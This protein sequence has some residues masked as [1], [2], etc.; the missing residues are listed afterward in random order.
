[1][2]G[3]F[4][5]Y[6][7]IEHVGHIIG[8]GLRVPFVSYPK[9]CI[10]GSLQ[11]FWI[12]FGFCLGCLS[13]FC[14]VLLVFLYISYQLCFWAFVPFPFPPKGVVLLGLE[15]F[16]SG[17]R[18]RV[19]F[20]CLF[21]CPFGCSFRF[22]SMF[23]FL[24]FLSGVLVLWAFVGFCG[25]ANQVVFSFGLFLRFPF[26]FPL[27]LSYGFAFGLPL[28]ICFGLPLIHP[29]GVLFGFLPGFLL[30]F[31]LSTS[32]PPVLSTPASFWPRARR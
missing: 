5:T 30:G 21:R 22:P 15:G 8:R 12:P 23:A 2:L 20:K 26:G 14:S 18:K 4:L 3:S 19:A 32:S 6:H 27:G 9:P 25:L 10:S 16:R 29:S 13:S 7:L 24:G 28:G 11:F 17:F 1:M 31:L